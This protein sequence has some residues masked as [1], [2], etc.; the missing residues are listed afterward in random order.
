M[1]LLFIYA[2]DAIEIDVQFTSNSFQYLY[3]QLTN[4]DYPQR[5]GNFLCSKG[6]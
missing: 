2:I 5:V 3:K 1:L 4:N 6:S